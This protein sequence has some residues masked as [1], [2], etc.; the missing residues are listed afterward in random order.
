MK[1]EHNKDKDHLTKAELETLI[2]KPMP[3][4]R[5]ER[6]RNVFTFCCLCR[7]VDLS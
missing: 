6:I 2:N 3:N 5:L 1:P 4:E 7:C